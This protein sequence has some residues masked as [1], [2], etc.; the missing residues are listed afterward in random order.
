[1]NACTRNFALVVEEGCINWN[2][3][4]W[5]PPI[6]INGPVTAVFSGDHYQID[7]VGNDGLGAG[8][9]EGSGDI[10]YTGTGCNCKAKI[11]RNATLGAFFEGGFVIKQDGV[12][13][14]QGRSSLYPDPAVNY[15]ILFSIGPGVNSVIHIEPYREVFGIKNWE[16]CTIIAPPNELHQLVT[17]SNV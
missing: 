17:F 16:G 14:C 13:I 12:V 1:M 15:Q 4:I 11:N 7:I 6:A 9:I 3:L 2:D 5:T 10:L 8:V